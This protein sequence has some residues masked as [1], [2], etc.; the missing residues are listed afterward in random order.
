[1]LCL[2]PFQNSRAANEALVNA[3]LSSAAV[4]L[5]DSQ[6]RTVLAEATAAYEQALTVKEQDTAEAADLFSAAADKYQLLV[7]AG[8]HNASLYLN[9]G[10]SYLQNNNAG[11][12]ATA[13]VIR[14]VRKS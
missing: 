13:T 1:M 3:P 2:M 8:I 4:T 10:N 11:G 5:S 9:L 12:K 7:D 14:N 6:K